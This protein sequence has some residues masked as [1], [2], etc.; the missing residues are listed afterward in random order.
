MHMNRKDV[1]E[2]IQTGEGYTS[3]FKAGPGNSIG[4]EICAFANASG[5][6]IIL[7]VRDDGEISGCS[8]KNSEIS[9]IQD[10]AR[11]M[12]P[13]F[14]VNIEQ[15]DDLAV[16]FV[17]EGKQ[18]PYAV[19]GHFYLRQGANSQQ[20]KRDEVRD[21]FQKENLI[22]FDRMVNPEFKADD[23]D[24]NRFGLFKEKLN[25]PKELS[26]KHILSN[27]ALMT[28]G[29]INNAGALFFSRS[30]SRLFLNAVIVGVVH[31][32]TS[33]ANILD[34]K[35]FDKDILSNFNDALNYVLANIHTNI[36]IV[37]RERVE[38][39]EIAQVALREA[40]INAIVHRDYFSNGRVQID[41]FSDRVEISNPGAL[42]FDKSKFGELSIA[43]NPIIADMFHRMH[44]IERIGSGVTRMMELEPSVVFDISSNWFK[45]IFKRKAI[46]K[47]APGLEETSQK[48]GEKT[49]EKTRVK[50]RVKIIE[51]I[52]ENPKI[53]TTE[54][55]D[56]T[57]L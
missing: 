34:K 35:E 23:F 43:R 18:K 26:K 30:I 16:I 47:G 51:L 49:G 17:P 21:L 40:I 20:L 56:K 46:E 54:L 38:R 42:L 19:N 3:E 14:S 15:I 6:K 50:T 9:Q 13:S 8:L 25:I 31:G 28:D 10:I 57:G 2:L 27:L 7:G 22:Q 39:P 24:D 48:T 41:I 1:F 55:A 12:D 37:G 44:F 36:S 45:A 52:K 11:N 33:R 4:K 53:T 5:G 32:G 29:K